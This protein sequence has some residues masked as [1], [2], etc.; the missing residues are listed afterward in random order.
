MVLPSH[1]YRVRDVVFDERG[2][3]VI[4]Q[5]SFVGFRSD[6]FSSLCALFSS[7]FSSF[8][9]LFERDSLLFG[10]FR[11]L[12]FVDGYYG[13]DLES[14]SFSGSRVCFRFIFRGGIVLSSSVL[15]RFSLVRSRLFP[16]VYGVCDNFSDVL[17]PE[18]IG[19][20]V[21]QAGVVRFHFS[22]GG[23]FWHFS[24]SVNSLS[25][26]MLGRFGVCRD[27][28]RDIGAFGEFSRRVCLLD[29]DFI[30]NLFQVYFRGEDLFLFYNYRFSSGSSS[31]R[32]EVDDIF[33]ELFG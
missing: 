6:K 26:D 2:F 5:G 17:V 29:E 30:L 23:S 32:S 13:Y 1:N 22:F 7:F 19:G 20:E 15:E 8:T 24:S 12:D 16:S 3:D 10:F 25:S 4:F 27:I 33:V 18:F 31:L 14:I 11:G 28:F 21:Y 9:Y